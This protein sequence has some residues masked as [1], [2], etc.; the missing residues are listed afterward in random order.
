MQEIQNERRFFS[1]AVI[2]S[3]ITE[4]HGPKNICHLKHY[5]VTKRNTEMFGLFRLFEIMD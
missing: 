3:F 4:K 5:K 1:L 2:L